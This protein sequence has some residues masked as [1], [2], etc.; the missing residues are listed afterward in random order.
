[1]VFGLFGGAS[2]KKTEELFVGDVIHYFRK[3]KAAVV[4]VKKNGITLGDDI[5]VK[6]HTTD[7]TDKVISMQIDHDPVE[8]AARGKEVAI[9]VKK[10]TRRGDKVYIV[11][12]K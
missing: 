5:R 10:K 12:S 2:R 6:G 9:R 3:V 1:M 7:F 11:G 8:K 4:K